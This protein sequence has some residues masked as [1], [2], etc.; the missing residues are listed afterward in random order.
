MPFNVYCADLDFCS[1]RAAA[2]WFFII[3]MERKILSV[4]GKW[5]AIVCELNESDF[6]GGVSK[7]QIKKRRIGLG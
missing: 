1:P 5:T 6:N 7:W 2:H 4:A 3:E